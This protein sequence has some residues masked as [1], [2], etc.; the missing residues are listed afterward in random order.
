M[1][2]ELNRSMHVAPVSSVGASS[3]EFGTRWS[4]AS[5]ALL[6]AVRLQQPAQAVQ[7]ERRSA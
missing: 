1:R 4:R 3:R 7:E 6:A 2:G 5:L